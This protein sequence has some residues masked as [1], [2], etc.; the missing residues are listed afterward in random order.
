MGHQ[1]R[2]F[3]PR[4]QLG[5]PGSIGGGIFMNAGSKYGSYGDILKQLRV[6][7]FRHG[8]QTLSRG[9][10]TLGIESKMR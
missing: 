2:L 10:F 4:I 6:F 1:Q 7:D 3:R 5:V 9:V 8:A